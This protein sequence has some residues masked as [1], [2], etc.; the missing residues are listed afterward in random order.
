MENV[1]TFGVK[2]HFVFHFYFFTKFPSAVAKARQRILQMESL[3]SDSTAKK[4]AIV[5]RKPSVFSAK[6]LL[7]KFP[8]SGSF[9]RLFTAQEL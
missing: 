6:F 9:R 3:S 8:V 7:I 4:E 1:K 2:S 5:N